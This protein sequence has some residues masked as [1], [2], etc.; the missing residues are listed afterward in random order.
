MDS[1]SHGAH[2]D[3]GEPRLMIPAGRICFSLYRDMLVKSTL[4]GPLEILAGP[5][6]YAVRKCLVL[7]MS[8]PP[9]KDGAAGRIRGPWS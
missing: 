4:L 3:V 1:C 9:G 5:G 2:L 6:P 7:M 8:V